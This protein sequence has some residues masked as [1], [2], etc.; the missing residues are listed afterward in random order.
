MKSFE[1]SLIIQATE[2]M[3][4]DSLTNS[5]IAWWT[6]MFEGS[7]KKNGDIFTIR[8]GSQIYKT[9]K[10]EEVILNQSVTWLVVDAL[11]D[12]PELENKKEWIGTRIIWTISAG[13][14][15]TTLRLKHIGLTPE[16]QCYELCKN[17]WQ[18]FLYSLNKYLTTGVGVPFQLT[19]GE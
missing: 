1:T 12:M 3:I 14:S 15:G 5:L 7:A 13:S 9:I 16:I 10:V 11:I 19:N 17:G 8:F 4:F 18:S 6:E 2:N